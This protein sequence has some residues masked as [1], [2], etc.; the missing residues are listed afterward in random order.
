[1]TQLAVAAGAKVIATASSHNFDFCKE[2]GASE[3]FDY[4]SSSVVDDVASAV[5]A[6]G[7]EFAGVFDA[8][9]IQDQSMKSSFDIVLKLGGGNMAVVLPPPKDKPFGV[10]VGMVLGLSPST[11][12]IWRSYITPALQEGK[13][14]CM[15][16]PLI[17]GN[18][19][20]A[21]QQGL[22]LSRSGVSAKKV[23]I[24]L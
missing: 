7:G 16:P 14:K 23:V 2:C 15:P 17:V 4:K 19:L 22:D 20:E 3:V 5:R 8:V 21:V 18:G 13:L 24:E 6:T 1:M 12:K 11:H 9:S 10:T